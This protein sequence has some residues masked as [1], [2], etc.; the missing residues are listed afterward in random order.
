MRHESKSNGE[1]SRFVVPA[2]ATV[3]HQPAASPRGGAISEGGKNALEARRAA[4]VW[5]EAGKINVCHR[6]QPEARFFRAE[7]AGLTGG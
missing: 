5:P 4:T 3:A 7:L 1:R 2:V 6:E